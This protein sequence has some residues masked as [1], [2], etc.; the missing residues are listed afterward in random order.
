LRDAQAPQIAA[1]A[2]LQMLSSLALDGHVEPVSLPSA[3]SKLLI[4]TFSPGCPACQAN[5]DGWTRLASML[6]QKGVRVL[7]ISGTQ[8]GPRESIASNTGLR[9]KTFS[10]TT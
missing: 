10:T 1:G 8:S 6:E 5:Q 9:L 3:G 7:W 4:I 2:Q